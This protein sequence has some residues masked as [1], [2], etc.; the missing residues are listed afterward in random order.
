MRVERSI[1]NKI[2]IPSLVCWD[3]RR[4]ACNTEVDIMVIPIVSYRN[5]KSIKNQTRRTG[6]IGRGTFKFC[7]IKNV[8]QM[9]RP[10]VKQ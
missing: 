2:F 4:K 8:Y 7:L 1:L 10:T 6:R 3:F 9:Q 5:K